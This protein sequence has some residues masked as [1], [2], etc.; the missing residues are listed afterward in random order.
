MAKKV[1]KYLWVS[2]IFITFA[3]D[4]K[5]YSIWPMNLYIENVLQMSCWSCN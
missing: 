4:F 1:Q 2:I 3:A 5:N